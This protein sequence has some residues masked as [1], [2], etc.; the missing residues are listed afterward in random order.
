MKIY[1]SRRFFL[2]IFLA[3]LAVSSINTF[4]QT[5]PVQ[6]SEKSL[7]KAMPSVILVLAGKGDGLLDKLGSGVIIRSDGVILTAYHVV[8]DA[9]QVQIRLK[10]GEIYD[11]VDLLDFD[12]RRDVAAL[13]ISA[14]DLPAAGISGDETKTGAKVFVISNPQSLNWTVADGLLSSVRLADEIPNAG[15]G[16]RVL[17]FSAPVS[18][19]SSG[20]LL[21]DENGQAIG[22]IVSSLSSGQNLNFAIPLSS[23]KGLADTAKKTMS[24]AKA[25]T[26][27]LPQAVRP[28]TAIDVL[29]TEPKEILRNAKLFYISSD[30]E[31]ISVKMMERALLKMPEFDKWK[32]SLIQEYKNADIVINV[33]HQLFTFDYRYTMTDRKT[34]IVLASGKV[35]VWDGGMASEKFAKQ[36][37]AK[38]KDIKAD[39]ENKREAASKKTK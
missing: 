21:T 24:F 12:E 29:N 19:G 16:F 11:K 39:S 14:T 33:E 31:L 18:A 34:S 26:L 35:T 1:L 23:V 5:A 32:L 27:E 9:A 22:L 20:G 3:V 2:P 28:P 25:D 17:Q 8:K 37:I 10:N 6:T 30:S 4:A 15:H 13:K 38:L 7:E 36:I